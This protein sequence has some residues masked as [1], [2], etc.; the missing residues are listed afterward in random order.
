[1]SVPLRRAPAQCPVCSDGLLTL[2]LGCPSCGTEVS[3]AFESC[4]YCR[5]SAEDQRTLEVFLRSRGNMRD[6]QAHLGV[7]YPTARQRFAEILIRLGFA[8]PE[9]APDQSVLNDLAQGRISVDQA[10]QIL[11]GR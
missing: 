1:M 9:T 7:S 5:L 10:E 8:E 11:E 4:G 3:G 6:L 2:R